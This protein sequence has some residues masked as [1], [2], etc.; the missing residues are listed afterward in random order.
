M[1]GIAHAGGP[2]LPG[3]AQDIKARLSPREYQVFV[4]MAHGRTRAAIAQETGLS[5][6][7]VATYRRRI[8]GKLHVTSNAGLALA[9][10]AA[11]LVHVRT[12]KF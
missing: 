3:S 6:S 4:A 10:Q 7:S 8:L 11:G 12:V 9:A 5:P 1:I 2:D